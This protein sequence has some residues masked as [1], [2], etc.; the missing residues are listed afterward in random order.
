M[1]LKSIHLVNFRQFR[2][3]K[4]NF[5]ISDKEKN[6]TVIRATNSTGKTTLMQSIKW[7]LFGD[8]AVELQ[9]GN[10]LI[11]FEEREKAKSSYIDEI[12]YSVSLEIEEEGQ[13]YKLVRRQYLHSSNSARKEQ[14]LNFEYK[15]NGETKLLKASSKDKEKTKIIEKRINAL[16]SKQM[17]DYFLFDGERIEKLAEATVESRKEISNA[18]TAVSSIPM[19]EN[20]IQTLGRLEKRVRREESDAID[21][22]E[23]TA[24][25]EEISKTEVDLEKEK[26][27]LEEVENEE[28]KLAQELRKIDNELDRYRDIKKY[29]ERRKELENNIKI[30]T[31]SLK[32]TKKRIIRHHSKYQ[33]NKAV[34]MLREKFENLNLSSSESNKTI[35]NMS[36]VAIENIIERNVCICGKDIDESGLKHLNDQKNYQPPKSP[37]SMIHDYKYAVKEEIGNIDNQ[38]ES[39]ESHIEL[40]YDRIQEIDSS[41]DELTD[42]N[43]I[44]NE[45]DEEKIKKLNNTR[46][47]T[48]LD[49]QNKHR[50][51]GELDNEVKNIQDRLNRLEDEFEDIKNEHLKSELILNRSE[52][53]R[54]ALELLNNQNEKDRRSLRDRIEY[55][56]NK[57][58]SEIITKDKRIEIDNSFRHKIKE[59]NG[60]DA[61]PSSG[62]LIAVSIS[63]ILAIIDTH[64]ETIKNREKE[65]LHSER[66]FFLVMDGP[67][68]TLDQN[69]SHTIAQKLVNSVEQIIL[70]TN[71]NQYSESVKSAMK[72]K[73]SKEYKL[74]LPSDVER[75]N[76]LETMDLEEVTIDEK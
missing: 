13:L 52:I 45:S 21:H 49:K 61:A 43:N 76:S 2:N 46:E 70:L 50:R 28:K 5:D 74:V 56:S 15:D 57:H 51:F 3:F 19:L 37:E 18:I 10:K 7:C 20:A 36:V 11:N 64:K 8:S 22:T 44:L 59:K 53:L 67:F 12:D 66:D 47:K 38:I 60:E 73:I 65:G 31:E 58:F 34:L 25:E 41:E 68:A 16:I 40:Y 26:D 71:D 42:I 33:F 27:E 4:I 6:V 14:I 75:K 48:M 17:A 55:F 9:S 32:D 24:L 1:R 72:E 35:P 23:V 30:S 54:Q 62:E 63:I 29:Q 39:I 69:Y